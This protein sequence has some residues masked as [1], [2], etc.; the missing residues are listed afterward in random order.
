MLVNLA[1]AA[2]QLT[3]AIGKP[4]RYELSN[5]CKWQYPTKGLIQLDVSEHNHYVNLWNEDGTY[6]GRVLKSEFVA[7]CKQWHFVKANLYL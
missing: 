5:D 4:T 6:F 2:Y 7:T 1:Y 3:E